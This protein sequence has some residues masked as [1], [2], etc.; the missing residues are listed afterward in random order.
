[1]TMATSDEPVIGPGM[2]MRNCRH[3]TMLYPANDTYIGR[4]LELYGEYSP[5]ELD[6]YA[7]ILRPG[8]DVIDAG[9]NIGALTLAFSRL[10]GEKGSVLAFE[11]QRLIYH[12]LC[13]NLAINAIENVAAAQVALGA[14][15]G[16]I[17]VPLLRPKEHLNFGGLTIGGDRGEPARVRTIDSMPVRNLRLIKIDVEGAELEVIKGADQTIRRLRPF[18][19]VENDRADKSAALIEALFQLDYRLWWQ[20]APLYRKN[21][22]RGNTENVFGQVGSWNMVGVPREMEFPVEGTEVT[23]STTWL[24]AQF[25]NASGSSTL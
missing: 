22:F 17:R 15:P 9:A 13:A 25:G 21:N 24:P 12:V 4:S 6:F 23:D 20:F 3:G 10:V 11:P 8:D 19:Y 2:A 18:L 7:F 1:M 5:V 16:M 14:E